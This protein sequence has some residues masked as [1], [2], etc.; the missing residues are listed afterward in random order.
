ML[1]YEYYRSWGRD[2]AIHVL[3]CDD[4]RRSSRL[5]VEPVWQARSERQGGCCT[6]VT[7]H[8]HCRCRWLGDGAIRTAVAEHDR[9]DCMRNSTMWLDGYNFVQCC[10]YRKTNKQWLNL[11]L[12]CHGCHKNM[13]FHVLIFI[14][15]VQTGKKLNL[16]RSQSAEY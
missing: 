15:Y 12:T 2:T 6:L 13:H 1:V 8:W 3:F 7:D 14:M 5:V 11:T 16:N 4:K 10:S 9:V